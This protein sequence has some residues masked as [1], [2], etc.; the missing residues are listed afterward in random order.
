MTGNVGRQKATLVPTCEAIGL[1]QLLKDLHMTITKLITVY[2]DNL[3]S[4]HLTM[5]LVF[6][7]RIEYII[8]HEQKEP[9]MLEQQQEWQTRNAGLHLQIHDHSRNKAT[10]SKSFYDKRNCTTRSLTKINN[11]VKTRFSHI[12]EP[13]SF[14]YLV[15]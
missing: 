10:A 2:C 6:H 3:N 1:K 13:T 5:N 11:L 8:V 9:Q 14:M 7:T 4:F 12:N 15:N